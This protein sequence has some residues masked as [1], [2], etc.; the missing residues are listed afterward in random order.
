MTHHKNSNGCQI[1]RIV[2]INTVSELNENKEIV[3]HENTRNTQEK[4]LNDVVKMLHS[5]KGL[6][7][8][9]PRL[10]VTIPT[11]LHLKIVGKWLC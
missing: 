6:D 11:R 5:D 3:K 1:N 7:G 2:K 9:Y 4:P 10:D 8:R